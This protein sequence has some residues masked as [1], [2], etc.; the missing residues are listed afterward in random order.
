MRGER[1][2]RSTSCEAKPLAPASIQVPATGRDRSESPVAKELREA[3]HSLTELSGQST[4]FTPFVP[5]P[6]CRRGSPC[7]RSPSPGIGTLRLQLR[8]AHAG[9]RGLWPRLLGGQRRGAVMANPPPGFTGAGPC[10]LS[11]YS[12]SVVTSGIVTSDPI[13]ETK[14]ICD[15]SLALAPYCSAKMTVF[16]AAGIAAIVIMTPLMRG[17]AKTG[18]N[19]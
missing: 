3:E 19:R 15:A 8:R 4:S 6:V 1:F 17:S 2:E 10:I 7:R 11:P 9:R 18:E 16:A 5:P 14:T 13:V 12:S